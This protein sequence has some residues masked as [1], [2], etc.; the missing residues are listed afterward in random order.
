MGVTAA[1]IAGEG[2]ALGGGPPVDA[3]SGRMCAELALG[4]S[5]ARSA[6]GEISLR[7]HVGRQ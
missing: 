7:P 3:P 5:G 4:Y 2:S 6:Q 1:T